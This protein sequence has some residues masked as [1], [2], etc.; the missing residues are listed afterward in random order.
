IIENGKLY[1][2]P[3]IKFSQ[4]FTS[5]GEGGLMGIALDP[6]YS[7]NHYIYV[8]HSYIECIEIYNRVV[9]LIEYSIRRIIRKLRIKIK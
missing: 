8:M 2:Q 7:Q 3:L 4:P 6:N 1:P 5:Q 9:R